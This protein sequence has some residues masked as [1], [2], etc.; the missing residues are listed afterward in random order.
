M[1]VIIVDVDGTLDLNGKPNEPLIAVLN[2]DVANGERVVVVAGR[3]DSRL[4][5]TKFFLDDAGLGYSE[6]YL[7]DF[8]VGPMRRT[9]SRNTRFRSLSRTATMSR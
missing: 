4:R 5:E 6:I 9:H 3:P 8:P 2:K 7:S 1:S